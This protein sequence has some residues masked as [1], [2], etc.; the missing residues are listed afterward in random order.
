MKMGGKFDREFFAFLIFLPYQLIL[1]EVP[2][3]MR[4]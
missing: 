4:R 3:L 2:T 1:V